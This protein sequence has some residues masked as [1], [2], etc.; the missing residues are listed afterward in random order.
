MAA[1]ARARAAGSGR[2]GSSGGPAGGAGRPR[3]A[4]HLAQRR[5]AAL[6]E[7]VGGGRPRPRA[8]HRRPGPPDR[9][10]PPARGVDARALRREP[11]VAP[12]GPAA[13]GGAGADL[14]PAGP[15]RRSERR[16]G[17]SRPPGS[18]RHA[19]L[20]PRR[21]HVRRALRR[22]GSDRTDPG[23]GS[24][25]EPGPGGRAPR[26]GPLPG[27]SRSR[28]ARGRRGGVRA[29][30]HA[31]PRGAGVVDRQPGAGA[32]AADG[33]VHRHPPRRGE[34]RSPG[35]ERHH[36]RGSRQHRPGRRRRPP[37]A[38]PHPHGAATSAR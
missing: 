6:A 26:H 24:G 2:R 17:R 4:R 11:G 33:R 32:D 12:R 13:P 10:S 8:R 25:P 36:R 9:R 30:T 23:R 16:P 38:G 22:V 31:L 28:G 1:S 29:A 14:D 27:P 5:H 20:P 21:S 15:G 37:A 19:L 7:D 34:R 3:P 35:H 18:H